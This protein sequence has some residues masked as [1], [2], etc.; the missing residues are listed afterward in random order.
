MLR[1]LEMRLRGHS[2]SP[3][4]LPEAWKKA[5][6]TP[7]FQEGKNEDLGNSRR[8][9]LTMISEK[10]TEPITPKYSKDKE[11]TGSSYNRLQRTSMPDN[12]MPSASK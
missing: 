9:S 6:V 10:V 3:H 2:P 11:V 4:G 1:E 7:A 5:T 12:L 8:V